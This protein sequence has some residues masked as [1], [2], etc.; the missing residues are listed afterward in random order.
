MSKPQDQ[1]ITGVILVSYV[2]NSPMLIPCGV[3]ENIPDQDLSEPSCI[4][5]RISWILRI[6]TGAA[7]ATGA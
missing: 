7:S 6:A 4:Y 3:V 2:F 1:G 5:D